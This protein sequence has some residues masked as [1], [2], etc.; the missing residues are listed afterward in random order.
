M[1]PLRSLVQCLRPHADRLG[2]RPWLRARRHG[3]IR[4]ISWRAAD[5]QVRALAAGLIERGIEPGDRVALLSENRPE[6][7]IA[8]L[9]I[10]S[11]GGVSVPM[12]A[13]L[14]A[15]Q[16]R[17]Q[18]ADCGAKLTIAST[19]AQAAKAD[20]A[21][22]IDDF[23][24][25]AFLER[26]RRRLTDVGPEI[27]RRLDSLA[28]AD[29]A[30]ILYTSG[31]TGEPKGVMLS[32][33]NL[34]SN[35]T[36]MAEATGP[37]DAGTVFFNWLPLS[38][39]YA[40]TCDANLALLTGSGLAFAESAET[41]LAD[42]AEM[43]PTQFSS[44]PRFYEKILGTVADLPFEARRA[45]LGRIF[46]GLR[47][48][49]T[50]GAPMPLAVL[51]AYREAGI[52]IQ[53]GYGLTETSPV[54]ATTR[55]HANRLGSVGPPIDGIEVRIADDGEVQ[56]RGPHVMLGYWNCPSP[57]VDGWFATGDLGRLDADGFLTITGRKKELIVLSCGKKVAP[58]RIEALLAREPAIEQAVVIGDGKPYLTALVAPRWSMLDAAG[59]AAADLMTRI[60]GVLADVAPWER[61]RKIAL[62]PQP[63][64]AADGEMTLSGKLRRAVIHDR[65]RERIE[66][67]YGG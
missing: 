32:H 3:V 18:I 8:D 63:F 39:V 47:W 2:E 65:H 33:G 10:Q 5:T 17:H 19:P 4:E 7:V 11:A 9:A 14:T 27:A 56:T 29:L 67:L 20:A 45:R 58:T 44:V 30:T 49:S 1:T 50:G 24:W 43:R 61:V 62:V 25:H 52:T 51:E 26:G 37:F 64:S 16:I 31:T 21:L 6:W 57:V 38:H 46:A 40:R 54:I 66:N 42:L 22:C 48:L 28:S 12:H 60:D 35:A 23:A 41:V 59:D 55:R 34:L 36:A 15:A 13:P 53:Q